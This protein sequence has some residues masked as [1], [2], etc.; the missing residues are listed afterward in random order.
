MSKKIITKRIIGA[1]MAASIFITPVL[2]NKVVYAASGTTKKV[3]IKSANNISMVFYQGEVSFLPVLIEVTLSDNTKGYAGGVRWDKNKIDTSKIG[4]FTYQ[5]TLPDYPKKIILTVTVQKYTRGNFFSRPDLKN[6]ISFDNGVSLGVKIVDGQAY[7]I[8]QETA[9]I[10]DDKLYGVKDNSKTI[11]AENMKPIQFN[12]DKNIN[13]K[14][15]DAAYALAKDGNF[16]RINSDNLGVALY[17]QEKNYTYNGRNQFSVEIFN[18]E[19]MNVFKCF[20]MIRMNCDPKFEK[21]LTN[22]LIG[23]Y[24]QEKGA[25]ASKFI[26]D[27]KAKIRKDNSKYKNYK[28]ELDLGDNI[29][30]KVFTNK[31]GEM[32]PVQFYYKKGGSK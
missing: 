14:I 28:T 24:G 10:K 8:L 20:M 9:L 22:T 29:I 25:K 4:T 16:L 12:H 26:F 7:T 23:Y 32:Q 31:L 15:L 5:G 21:R 13:E 19:Y 3:T 6:F 18:D 17:F 11:S 30:V 2:E 1:L 27:T